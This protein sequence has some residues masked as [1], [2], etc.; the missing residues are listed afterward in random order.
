MKTIKKCN[1]F[2]EANEKRMYDLE[3]EKELENEE[4]ISEEETSEKETSE[5]ETMQI[6]FHTDEEKDEIF[7]DLM[8][9]ARND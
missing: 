3:I 2:K 9:N 1:D 5:K 7:A 6:G 4:G 8:K